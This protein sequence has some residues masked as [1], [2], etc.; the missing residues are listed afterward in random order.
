MPHDCPTPAAHPSSPAATATPASDLDA[1]RIVALMLAELRK[2]PVFAYCQ[3]MYE[4][5]KQPDPDQNAAPAVAPSATSTTTP[6]GA[7]GK[8]PE[9]MEMTTPA[10]PTA[11]AAAV[12]QPGQYEAPTTPAVIT[13]PVAV[14]AQPAE[15]DALRMYREQAAIQAAQYEARFT[16]LS[17]EN[18]DLRTRLNSMERE[19]DLVQ[20]EAEGYQFDRAKTLKT[21]ASFTPEQYQAWQVDARENYKRRPVGQPAIVLAPTTPLEDQ[22]RARAA[23]AAA[24]AN[25]PEQFSKDD[26]ERAVRLTETDKISYDAAVAKIKAEKAAAAVAKK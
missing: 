16:N 17:T 2:D 21:V 9:E 26:R 20:M 1:Q 13:T 11:A 19:R 14:T 12:T 3:Q 18:A 8:D 10:T 24:A 6:A 5:S 23:Q 7:G 25:Q 15:S 22:E 4:Q